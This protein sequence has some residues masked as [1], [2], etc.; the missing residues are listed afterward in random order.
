MTTPASK[1]RPRERDTII[2]A[3]S[4][5]VVPRMGL[6]YIQVGRAS[7]ISAML[8]DIDRIADGGSAVRFI[9]GD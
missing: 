1:I 7:E 2:Q 4:A 6:S 9:I 8:R 5:G 3:L